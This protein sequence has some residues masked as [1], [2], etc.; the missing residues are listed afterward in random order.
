M[1]VLDAHIKIGNYVFTSIH[2]VEIT[3]SVDELGDT[4][5]IQL[6]TRFK[7]KQ[8]NQE[9]YTEEAIKIGDAVEVVLGYSGKYSGIEF[10]GFVRKIKPT[11]PLQIECEDSIWL[12]RRK[13]ITKAWNAG[14]SV[15]GVL[16]EVVKNTEVVL[17]DNL[18][19]I[20]LDKYII[21]NANGAQVLQ[22]LKKDMSLTVFINDNNKLYVG[23]QQ[24]DNPGN[25]VVYDLNYN[26]VENN[27]EYTTKDERRIKVRYTYIGKNNERKEVEVGDADGELRTFHTSVI[28]DETKLKE[29]ATAEID[30]LKYD[31]FDGNVKSFLMPF[32][33]RGMT[34]IIIDKEHPNR[35]GN[36]FIKKVVTTFGLHGARRTITLGTRL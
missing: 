7:V 6:P 27:L 33:T 23:L 28:S 29:I 11:I 5:V 31:G 12:L 3:K 34:A 10:K 22:A 1:F 13:N 4:C 36:Y 21:R 18:P 19:D 24:L 30:R 15:K 25:A 14:T 16:Q 20:P 35:A 17:S 26:L 2:D 9:Q 8:N 32:A